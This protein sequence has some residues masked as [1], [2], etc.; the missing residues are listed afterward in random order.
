[1]NDKKRLNS[2]EDLPLVLDV[3]D[4]QRIMGISRASAYELVHTPGFPAFRR[5]RLIKVSKIAFFEWM[6]KGSE[7]IPGSDKKSVRYYHLTAIL[8]HFPKGHTEGKN[9]KNDTETL[10]QNSLSAYIR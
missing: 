8:P 6:A 3:A 1:M 7:T 5:G 2:Y 9:L 4:I 10:H